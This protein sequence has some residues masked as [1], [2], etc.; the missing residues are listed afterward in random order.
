MYKC[1]CILCS[2]AVRGGMQRGPEST[3]VGVQPIV[4]L[5][6]STSVRK[7]KL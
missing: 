3:V 2:H 5:E 1:E 6:A 4:L 7:Q